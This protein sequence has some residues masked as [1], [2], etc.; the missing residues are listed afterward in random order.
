[1]TLKIPKIIGHRGAAGYAPE[2][3]L[4]SI[5]TAAEMGFDWV[6]FDVKL[7]KDSVPILF[8]DET[9]DRTTNG[10]GKV[11]DT[12]FEEIRELE[13]GSWFSDG[14]AGVQV[15]SLEETIEVLI[16]LNMAVNMEIK[17]CPNRDKETAEMAI[18]CLHRRQLQVSL[19]RIHIY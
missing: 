12:T 3:T 7:T 4:D 8:H 18:P 13:A 10:H 6:E 5:K 9:L 1:M 14:F 17:P 11:A 16:D 19:F 2:N 15:P